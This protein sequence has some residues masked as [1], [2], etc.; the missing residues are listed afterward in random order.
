MKKQNILEQVGEVNVVSS[1]EINTQTVIHFYRFA[2]KQ[3]EREAKKGTALSS[4]V[5]PQLDCH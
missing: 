5:P 4:L 2:K 1:C 3:N